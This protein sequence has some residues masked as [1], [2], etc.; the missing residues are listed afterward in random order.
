MKRVS[1]SGPDAPE[2]LPN[3]DHNELFQEEEGPPSEN[4]KKKNQNNEESKG[5][6]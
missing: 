4:R 3:E 6:A 2:V 5:A 1:Q